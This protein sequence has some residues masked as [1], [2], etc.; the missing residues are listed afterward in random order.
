MIMTYN[1][2]K[3][4]GGARAK[5]EMVESL[6]EIG[7]GRLALAV[8]QEAGSDFNEE[9]VDWIVRATREAEKHCERARV[10]DWIVAQRRRHWRWAG[11]VRRMTDARWTVQAMTWT[12]AEGKRHVGRPK[13][14]WIDD[15]NGY[16]RG[17][18]ER[19]K[20]QQILH[21]LGNAGRASVHRR[22]QELWKR[23]ETS[24]VQFESL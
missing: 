24:F 10:E 1:L 17:V 3:K 8:V 14:R 15:I 22:W 2:Q 11:H 9:W 4:K 19:R 18:T 20:Q 12:P 5:R 23:H 21:M 13:K 16:A 7:D 6:D